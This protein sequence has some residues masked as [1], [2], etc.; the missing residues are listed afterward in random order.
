MI[1]TPAGEMFF[2]EFS[3]GLGG[4]THLH[5]IGSRFLGPDYGT[6]HTMLTR[7]SGEVPS[8]EA[9]RA[10]LLALGLAFDPATGSGVLVTYD[11]TRRSGTL[12]CCAVA[13]TPEAAPAMEDALS[14]S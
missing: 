2:S 5:L 9:A 10:H 14:G 1:L 6:S 3:G 4:T 7:N 8:L 11:R 13:D 12:E